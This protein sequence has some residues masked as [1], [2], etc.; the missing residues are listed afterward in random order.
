MSLSCPLD[1]SLIV[2]YCLAGRVKRYLALVI[3]EHMNTGN[4]AHDYALLIKAEIV[5][6]DTLLEYWQDIAGVAEYDAN[7]SESALDDVKESLI[8]L[9][10]DW[11]DDDGADIVGDYLNESCLDVNVWRNMMRTG[12]SDTTKVEILRTCGGPRCDIL[13]D[14]DDGSIV[15]IRVYSGSDSQTLRVTTNMLADYLDELAGAY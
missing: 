2:G 4:S 13:R 6:L 5:A 11:P 9:E 14:S 12:C 10:L 15:E 7:L 3:G 1:I 8:A